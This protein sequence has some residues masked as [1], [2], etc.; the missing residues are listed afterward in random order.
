[1]DETLEELKQLGAVIVEK[2]DA[3]HLSECL[4]DLTSSG[5]HRII[6]NF[7][8]TAV[9]GGQDGQNDA[10][11]D[12]K[13]LIRKFVGNAM[14]LLTPCGEIQMCHK[15]KPPFD[16]WRLEQVALEACSTCEKTATAIEKTNK[17]R[18]VGRVVL[19]K[20]LFPP[21]T[22]RKALCRK[23]FPCHDAC[24]YIFAKENRSSGLTDEEMPA[25]IPF[26]T[27]IHSSIDL[28]QIHR[29]APSVLLPVTKEM[30]HRLRSIF[31]TKANSTKQKRKHR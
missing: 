16:Q 19:D 15:T 30:I 23:S 20:S 27:N 24:I 7:P 13:E 12:N 8:C 21:Y 28:S 11:E 18:Y 6:W 29:L 10:M 14:C 3:T 22:P 2:V 9:A 17:I 4:P 26:E 25:S 5:F 1:L 31:L